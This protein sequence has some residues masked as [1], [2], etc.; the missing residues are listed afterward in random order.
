M[1]PTSNDS[2]LLTHILTIGRRMVELRSLDPLLDYV[3][4]EVLSLIEGERGYIFLANGQGKLRFHKGRSQEKEDL[5][6]DSH[7]VSTTILHEAVEQQKTVRVS[8]AMCDQRFAE[9]ISVQQLKLLSV[10]CAPLVSQNEAIGAIYV[11]NSTVSGRF[12]KRHVPPIEILAN[13]AAVSIENAR[14]NDQLQQ[15]NH[16]LQELNE[17]KNNF[18]MLISHELRTPLTSVAIYSD[19]LR[20]SL[21]EEADSQVFE[22]SGRLDLAI[23]TLDKLIQ[24]IIYVFRIMSGRLDLV[25]EAVHPYSII[26]AILSRLSANISERALTIH[27]DGVADLPTIE[28]DPEHLLIAMQNVMSNAVK[29]TPDGKNIWVNGRLHT[30]TYSKRDYIVLTIRDEGIGIPPAE[31]TRVFDMFHGLGSLLNHSTSKGKY[32]G[33]GL[34]LGL[35]IAQGV[36]EGHDGNIWLESSGHDETALPGTTCYIQLPISVS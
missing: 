34:G 7:R 5:S 8:N 18:I 14:L 10:I 25:K 33:G 23:Q 9:S 16:Y 13:Q 30:D 21:V 35:P 27:V 15:A 20:S 19:L 32:R 29:Y 12:K 28:A 4:D 17:L 1:S 2:E 6:E 24:E 36:V 3:L 22:I 31:Q 26:E 11:E